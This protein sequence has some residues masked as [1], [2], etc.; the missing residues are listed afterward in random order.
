MNKIKQL[1]GINIPKDE[2]M[3]RLYSESEEPELW[4]P[5]SQCIIEIPVE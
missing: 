1:F 4:Q 2:Q 5:P 3:I